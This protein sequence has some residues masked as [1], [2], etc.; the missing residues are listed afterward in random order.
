MMR[1]STTLFT[2]KNVKESI[3]Y[4]R[5]KIGFDVAFEYGAPPIVSACARAM[6]RSI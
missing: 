6:S 1:D 2:V 4:Y 5:G 3:A